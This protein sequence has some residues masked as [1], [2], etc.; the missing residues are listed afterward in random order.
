[1]LFLNNHFEYK[2]SL[3]GYI[4]A[5]ICMYLDTYDAYKYASSSKTNPVRYKSVLIQF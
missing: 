3:D 1:M 5:Y 2:T 4:N